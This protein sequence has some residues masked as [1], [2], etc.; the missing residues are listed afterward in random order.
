MLG[1]DPR[2]TGVPGRFSEIDR[3]D[4]RFWSS[5]PGLIRVV[6][7]AKAIAAAEQQE[8]NRAGCQQSGM[9]YVEDGSGVPHGLRAQ[10]D[11]GM[12]TR[13]LIRHA[14]NHISFPNEGTRY[15]F[16]NKEKSAICRPTGL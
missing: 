10:V 16:I 3:K 12:A 4:R 7:Q 15:I 8:E 13:S 2:P 9:S 14:E 11:Y 1:R 6:A 5:H